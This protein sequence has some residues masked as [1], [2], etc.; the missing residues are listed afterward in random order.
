MKLI[1]YILAILS[2]GGAAYYSMNNIEMH[3]EQLA[4]TKKKFSEFKAKQ[5]AVADKEV[6]LQDEEAQRVAAKDTNNSL[7]ADKDIKENDVKDN[8][9]LSASFDDDIAELVSQKDKI[10]AALDEIEKELEGEKV[11][12]DQVE[13]FVVNLENKK[14][15]LNKTNVGLQE[16][17]GV[18]TEAVERNQATLTD[19]KKAQ[20]KRRMNLNSNGISSLITAVDDE[21]GFVVVKPHADSLIKQDSKLLV[22]RGN[23]HIG[24][25][26]IN[27]IEEEAGRVLANIDY[28]SIAP[29]MRIRPGDR[30]ILS[31]PLTQ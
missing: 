17:I 19:F 16:E 4:L 12:L 10:K 3:E 22:I 23:R 30:V 1:L 14:K 29:G 27:A 9:K 15:D 25:L 31:N 7:L 13:E 28:S 18:F 26:S 6:E 11:P 5:K 2:I 20:D 8:T 24:R 21:W